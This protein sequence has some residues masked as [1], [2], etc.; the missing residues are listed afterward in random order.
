MNRLLDEVF[1]RFGLFVVGWSGEWDD[2]LRV[3]LTRAPGQ[4]YPMY[5]ATREAP[6]PNAQ[7]IIDQKAARVILITDA[8]VLFA[9]LGDTLAAL[10]QAA[11][12]Y[13][14]KNQDQ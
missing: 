3:A 5:W 2:A 4:R 11:R 14:C 10:R 9:R 7:A 12:P 13:A 8:D 6:K 1:D